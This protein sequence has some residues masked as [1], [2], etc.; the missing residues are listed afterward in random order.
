MADKLTPQQ[1]AAIENRGGNLLV[2]A[3][4]G[5]GKTKVLT[6]RLLS[7]I[8]DPN[9]P[10]NVDDFLI[11]TFTKAAAAELRVKIAAKLSEAMAQYPENLHLQRQ[12]QRLHLAQ[13]S[14][15]HSFC[16]EILREYAYRLDI[17]N[18]FRMIDNADSPE[19]EQR[20]LDQVINASYE[21]ISEDE[22]F[23]KL[24]DTQGYGR[25]DDAIQEIVLKI[26]NS[27]R[28]H[29]NPDQWL[30][31]CLKSV[32]N[33][34]NIDASQTPW[35][36]FLIQDL[37]QFLDLQI[38]SMDNCAQRALV[39]VGMSGA[40]DLLFVT[41]EQ[42]KALRACNLWDEIYAFG[43]IDYGTLRFDK[44][45]ED[46]E[47]REQIKAVRKYCKESLEKK[48]L[49][50][51]ADSKQLLQDMET[52]A[53]A[54]KGL[55]SLVRAF[56]REYSRLK[57]RLRVLDFGDLEH[58]TLDLLLG[59]DHRA[60]NAL[61]REIGGRYREV[62]VDEYQDSNQVQDAI[63]MALTCEKNNCFMVGDV[64][65]SIYQF[66]L[67]DPGI[68]V[69]KYNTYLPAETA[70]VGQGRKIHLSHNFRSAGDVIDCVND[71]FSKCMSPQVGGLHYGEDEMLREGVPHVRNS[72][73]EISFYAVHT[74]GDTYAEEANVIAQKIVQLLDGTHTV[75]DGESLR[76]IKP[77]DI[78]ILIRSRS[79][80]SQLVTALDAA[81]LPY[82][83]MDPEDILHSMEISVL[84]SLLRVIS[85]PLQDIPLLSV[86]ASNV[87]TYSADDLA[88]LRSLQSDVPIFDLLKLDE[89]QK[90]KDFLSVIDML[91]CEAK[92]CTVSQ[93]LAKLLH[94]CDF[95]SIYGAMS[96][97]EERIKRIHAF[98]QMA[99]DFETAGNGNIDRFL[100]HLDAMDRFGV[101]GVAGGKAPSAIQITTIHK[102]KGL[103]Y[104]VVFLANTCRDFN[105]MDTTKPV[106]CDRV[107]GL[108]LNFLDENKRLSY[109]TVAKRAIS[110]KMKTDAISEEL[111][112]LYVAMTRARDRLIMTYADSFLPSTLSKLTAHMAL[113]HPTL[114]SAYASDPG[115]WL[116]LTALSRTEAGEL[117]ALGGNPG[118][119]NVSKNPW[120]IRVVKPPETVP[121]FSTTKEDSVQIAYQNYGIE[122]A[123][124]FEY[125][126]MSDTITPSKQTATQIKGRK[127]D[128][129]AAEYAAERNVRPTYFRK[130]TFL[131]GTAGKEYGN[132][133]HAIMQ[134]I[135]YEACTDM[136]SLKAELNRLV[137][138]HLISTEQRDLIN[139][140]KV[141]NFILSPLGRRALASVNIHREFKFSIMMPCDSRNSGD[142]LL[143]G[144]VDLII[145]DEDGLSVI[146]FKSDK[147]C[148]DSLAEHIEEHRLQVETY[149]Q[150][151]ERIFNQP[152]KEKYLYFFSLDREVQL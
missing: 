15:V 19:L 64:K 107:L 30:D 118:C 10:A 59:K 111:R 116:L 46:I 12:L 21:N 76:P 20:V 25:N 112:V 18:D 39:T 74:D 3:A 54:V 88:N 139:P 32:D 141:L 97:G 4:A 80:L 75:R 47:L 145:A 43:G 113:C 36:Q 96:D 127:K 17:G 110:T 108:G 126:Y 85:N 146:D 98:L 53:P 114:L 63:Y 86:L 6:E 78:A 66:R 138:K 140:A 81:N 147:V 5:S 91:R 67:A 142:V 150:A 48:L 56:G 129:E 105:M 135:R 119:S 100:E 65:Q 55:V 128:I 28:C 106:L 133:Y 49:T 69:E 117:F 101:S 124:S 123:M 68:F 136:Q 134:Y 95:I 132:A 37:H 125:P 120:E 51:S 44:N 13:I 8:L 102:S 94:K 14:T 33:I 130:P 24:I 31:W 61:A 83:T 121:C 42:M 104:P 26:Y 89:S 40:A 60:P 9:D 35:G 109:P 148:E 1:Q 45:C 93:L 144:V 52:T 151:V 122:M 22:N 38:A 72:E 143:Q 131:G 115:R 70:Q 57:R 137:D 11:I 50:F 149:C 71:V 92:V 84:I 90:S 23:R 7:Y 58:F 103:E 62:M 41:V 79:S 16:T 27:S 73:P 99:S 152:V 2:S 82:V 87:F 29:L 77:E 34:S